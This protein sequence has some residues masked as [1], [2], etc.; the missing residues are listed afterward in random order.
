LNC[1]YECYAINSRSLTQTARTSALAR[2]S[3]MTR[4]SAILLLAGFSTLWG[5]DEAKLVLVPYTWEYGATVHG[6]IQVPPGYKAETENYREGIITYLRYPD[7]S[8]IVLQQGGMYRVPMFQ[9]PEYLIS[10]TEDRADRVIRTGSIK[11][12]DKLWREDNWKRQPIDERPG[13][14]SPHPLFLLFPPNIAYVKVTKDKR[15][16]FNK[17]LNS[18]DWRKQ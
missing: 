5:K 12:S 16:L 14:Q 9:D 3:I 4:A 8:Y 17:A 11:G 10:K 18:F 15:D 2:L 13:E 1:H 6:I 7:S